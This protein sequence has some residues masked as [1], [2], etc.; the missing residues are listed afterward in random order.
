MEMV[1]ITGIIEAR[2][3]SAILLND[4]DIEEWIPL[5]QIELEFE[6]DVGEE[7]GILMPEWLAFDKGFI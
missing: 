1:E 7:V 5:S 3:D 2:T 6:V 4:G